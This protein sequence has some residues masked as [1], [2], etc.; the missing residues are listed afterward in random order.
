MQLRKGKSLGLPS[1]LDQEARDSESF[2]G[3]QNEPSDRHCAKA[4]CL[5]AEL[6]DAHMGESRGRREGVQGTSHE[7]VEQRRTHPQNHPRKWRGRSLSSYLDNAT[8][9]PVIWLTLARYL[10]LF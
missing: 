6:L 9:I 4:V 10:D 2:D 7:K 1:E 8:C 3:V 5:S